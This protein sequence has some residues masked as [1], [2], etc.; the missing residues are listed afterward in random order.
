MVA[1][2]IWTA[3]HHRREVNAYLNESPAI[4]R[5]QC[6][7]IM[8]LG[9]FDIMITLPFAIANMVNNYLEGHESLIFYPGWSYVHTD[10]QPVLI[11]KSEWS[12]DSYLAFSIRWNETINVVL[13]VIFFVLFGVTRSSRENYKQ[14]FWAAARIF[15]FKS[16][17]NGQ[18]SNIIFGTR[19]LGSVSFGAEYV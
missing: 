11:P 13:A 8:A 7:R 10:W 12:S 14:I 3:Y 2:I 6:Y 9:C 16:R 1:K 15:G 19:D 4:D 5:D 18:A 17:A